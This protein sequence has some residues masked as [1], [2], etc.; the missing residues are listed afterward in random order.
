MPL[1]LTF[2]LA[3]AL[4]FACAF[5]GNSQQLRRKGTFG[6]RMENAEEGQG[7][8]IVEG[9]SSATAPELGTTF[10]PYLQRPAIIR[11]KC[12]VF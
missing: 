7:I 3:F 4:F 12:N 10:D 9:L 11:S 5:S 2:F 8:H 1:N 6:A